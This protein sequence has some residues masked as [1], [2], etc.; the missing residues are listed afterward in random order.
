MAPL[1]GVCRFRPAT[2]R[3]AAAADRQDRQPAQARSRRR[4][5]ASPNAARTWAG[6]SSATS[7]TPVSTGN[8]IHVVHPTASEIDGVR[9]RGRPI[10]R[11]ARE[12]RSL[13]RRGRRRTGAR[14]HRRAHRPRRGQR[15]HPDP[16]WPRRE[17]GQPGPRRRP[18]GPHPRRP[19][20]GTTAARS[21]SAATRSASSPTRAA[22]TPCSSPT[23]SCRNRAATRP[24]ALL[25]LPVRRLHHLQPEPDAVARPGLRPLH[26]QP[27]RPH[28]RRS[29]RL[30]QGRPRDRGLRGLH[31]GLPARRRP[32]SSPA[33]VKE[34]VALGKDVVFYKAGRTIGGTVG[35][36]RSHRVGGRRL[37]GL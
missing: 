24:Q 4:S 35:D 10:A 34:T 18:Q 15:R 23:P 12:G 3:H 11:P 13:R 17:G 27:D 36:R 14:G 9:L 29:P 19:I 21:S 6:S 30:H 8:D 33:A 28:R 5:S 31:G 2:A 32:S 20:S 16:R 25:H 7:S 22:T 1:D 37:R 26:R